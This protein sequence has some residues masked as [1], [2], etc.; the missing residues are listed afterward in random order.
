MPTLAPVRFAERVFRI[1]APYLSQHPA[2]G[3]GDAREL[4]FKVGLLHTE[5]V[6]TDEET[7]AV[8]AASAMLACP[9][10]V[11]LVAVVSFVAL[12]AVSALVAWF[13]WTAYVAGDVSDRGFRHPIG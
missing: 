6:A 13:A 10:R 11:E 1:P 8:V 3:P 9:A 4:L 5:A 7:V 12:V 2:H